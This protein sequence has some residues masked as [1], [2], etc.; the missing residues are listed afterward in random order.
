MPGREIDYSILPE[1]MRKS[2]RLYIE[3]G[4]MTGAFQT[5]V[6][7][8]D[9]VHAYAFADHINSWAIRDFAQFLYSEAPRPCW[10]SKEAVKEWKEKGGLNGIFN[11]AR[12]SST[13][14]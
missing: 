5:A 12:H 2:V 6:F 10:G 11:N 7:E 14:N 1:H 4:V 8:N 9:L 13:G 3:D